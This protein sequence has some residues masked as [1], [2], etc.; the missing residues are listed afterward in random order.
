MTEQEVK[1][2]L[3]QTNAV[4]EGHFLLTSGLHSPMYVEKFNVLQHPRYTEALCKELAERFA[5]MQVQTVVGPMTGGIL[6][7]HEVGK[8]LGTRAI[9]TERVDGKMA[10]RRGFSLK[11][12][13]RVLIVE[14]IVTTGGSVK[15]VIDVVRS[16]G[17]VPV[18]VGLLVDRSG[19]K[20]DF[21][22]VPHKALLN[23]SVTAYKPEEC[24]L[25][26]NNIP[27]TKRGRTGK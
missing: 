15:E 26:K 12:G 2:L 11:R 4:M 10:F 25:C 20:A 14:D 5:D 13:E 1:D 21:G 23:L 17:A 27:M 3:M 24:P 18:G 8:A 19:G 9:F 7:A 22:D 16:E 6:L